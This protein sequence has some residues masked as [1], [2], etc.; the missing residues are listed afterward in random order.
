M[1][2]IKI[3]ILK[4]RVDIGL[5]AYDADVENAGLYWEEPRRFF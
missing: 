3:R 4:S 1:I 5:S 2:S